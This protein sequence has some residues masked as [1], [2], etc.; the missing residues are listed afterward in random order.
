MTGDVHHPI[1]SSFEDFLHEEGIVEAVDEAAVKEVIAWQVAQGMASRNL[2][3]S[4]MAEA[5]RTSRTQVDRLLDPSNT[6]VAL[7]TL[8]RAA[9]VLGKRLKIE[10][11]DEEPE[12]KRADAA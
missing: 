8:Y 12:G 9:A 3:K 7:H 11:V 4:A 10:F 5:M 2:S 6:G 1:G